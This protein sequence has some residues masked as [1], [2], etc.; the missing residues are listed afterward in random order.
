MESFAENVFLKYYINP[1]NMKRNFVVIVIFTISICWIACDTA[2]D[3]VLEQAL[4]LAGENQSEMEKVLAH[5]S[6]HPDKL[7]AARFLIRNMR[8]KYSLTGKVVDE[9]HHFIDSMYQIEQ[10]TYNE[11][12]INRLYQAK[13]IYRNMPG[14]PVPDLQTLHSEFLISHIDAAFRVWQ[15]PWN[16]NLSFSEFCE[17]ILP[18]RVGN[19][20]PETWRE[21]YC[22][23][24]A[25]IL[26]DSQTA[27]DACTVINNILIEQSIHIF[28]QFNKPCDIK[29]SSLLPIKFGLCSD[30]TNRA[31]YA[32]RSVGIPVAVGFIPHWGRSNNN[33]SFNLL[34]GGN[35]EYYDF[36]GGEQNPDTHLIR[37]EGIPK[38]YQK[39]YAMQHN[40]LSMISLEEIPPFFKN[41]CMKDI[42]EHFPFIHPQTVTIPLTKKKC[43]NQYVY[44]CVFDPK[45]WFPVDWGEVTGKEVKF[46]HIGPD[47]IY[48]VHCYEN[49]LLQPLSNPFVVDSV[50][51]ITTFTCK[52]VKKD[53]YLERKYRAPKHLFRIPPAFVGGKFQGSDNADFQKA[54]DLYIFTKAPNFKYTTIEVNPCNEYRYYRYIS[55]PNT[56]GNIAEVEFYEA[57]NP[58]KLTGEIIGT[59]ITSIYNPRATKENVFDGDPLTFFHTRD[60]MSW[61]GLALSRPT[62]INKIRYIIRNDDNGIRKNHLYELFYIDDSGQWASTGRQTATQDDLLVYPQVPQG[63]VYWL[64]DYTRGKE[65]RIFTYEKGEQVWW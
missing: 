34:Y 12:E 42:T 53:M 32:M 15:K 19:E 44:L 64:R 17:W 4:T 3:K 62:R 23:T 59:D 54:E 56:R 30:Y 5:Y 13:S 38:I 36:A 27:I 61:A 39:T 14:K 7:E 47:I 48:Q 2:S 49:G 21:P 50:G 26:T 37:F 58:K 63:T 35:E 60:T 9:F 10:E 25:G 40:S 20:L 46:D 22:H 51:K 24:F 33:H 28:N 41:P 65:E 57:N 31:I 1:E 11:E 6:D 52:S 55:S 18:Y 45:G 8:G 29:P 43:N 16:R